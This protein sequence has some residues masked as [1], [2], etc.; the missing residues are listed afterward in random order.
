MKRLVSYMFLFCALLSL[1]GCQS[2]PYAKTLLS[3]GESVNNAMNVYGELYRAGSL[4]QDQID[5]VR[6]KHAAYSVAY[7][8]AVDLVGHDLSKM[9][10]TEVSDLAFD[11]TIT[12]Y[13]IR[14]AVRK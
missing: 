5:T 6:A 11:L 14:S 8:K 7:A 3:V 9:S 2:T 12:I 1:D 10:P 13:N 4:S